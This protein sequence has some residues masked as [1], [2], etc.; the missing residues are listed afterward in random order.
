ML[1]VL[2]NFVHCFQIIQHQLE[3]SVHTVCKSVIMESEELKALTFVRRA[4]LRKNEKIRA[5]TQE[6]TDANATIETLRVSLAM[7]CSLLWV[8][9]F[10]IMLRWFIKISI[11]FSLW[12]FFIWLRTFWISLFSVKT[13]FFWRKSLERLANY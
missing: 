5:L 4:I 12:I 10:C 8:P 13:S 7:V 1:N 2:F 6:L 9:R 11:K 3:F